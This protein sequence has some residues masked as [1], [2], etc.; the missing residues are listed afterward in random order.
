MKTRLHTALAAAALMS[1]SA[2]G[3]CDAPAPDARTQGVP[4][5]AALQPAVDASRRSLREGDRGDPMVQADL[6]RYNA[7]AAMFQDDARRA[8]AEDSLYALWSR[9]LD[10]ILWPELPAYYF[11]RISELG[12]LQALFDQ[13]G[14]PDSSTALGAYLREWR[15]DG[16]RTD[17][18]GYDTARERRG[19][20]G[21]FENVWFGLRLAR[22]AIIRGEA[23]QGL[24]LALD[25]L[26][27]AREI[28]G[29]RLELVAWQLIAAA[30]ETQGA[31]DDALH[32]CVLAEDFAA[33]LARKTRNRFP[34]LDT[35]ARRAQILGNRREMDAAIGLY[36]TCADEADREGMTLL[37]QRIL[38]RA[39][40]L[41]HAANRHEDGLRFFQGALRLSLAEGDSLNVPRH[42][43]NIARRHRILGN[44]DSCRVYLD[45]AERWVYG[46]S[47]PVNQARFPLMQAEYHAQIGDFA[48][49]DSL[50]ALALAR[51]PDFSP[52][53]EFSELHLELIRTGMERGRPAQAYRSIAL[54][55]SLRDRLQGTFTDRH[56]IAD[57]DLATAEFLGRQGL[58]ARAADALDR[59]DS[60]LAR[61]PDPVRGVELAGARGHLARR[62][63]DTASAEAAY[64]ECARL[65]D[66]AGDA[67]RGE[68]ARLWLASVLLDRGR[69]DAADSVLSSGK[70]SGGQRRFRTRV[71]AGIL[72]ARVAAQRGDLEAA[73]ARLDQARA[74]CRPESPPDL[75]VQLD[76]DSG[77]S[78]AALGRTRAAR[79]AY[80]RARDRLAAERR[81]AAMD[82]DVFPDRDLR[83]E[84][85]EAMV[86]TAVPATGTLEGRDAEA[87]LREVATVLPDWARD[88]EPGGV[89]AL[90]APQVVYL[91]GADATYRWTVDGR[92]ITLHRL[93][94]GAEILRAMGP[95][96]ADLREPSRLPSPDD[97]AALTEMLGGPAPSGAD[98]APLVIVPDGVLFAIPWATLTGTGGG[99]WVDSGPIVV[100]D[101]PL[102][103][104]AGAS[105]LPANLRLLAVGVD[106][107]A[108]ARR[109]GLHPLRHAEREARDVAASWPAANAVLEVGRESGRTANLLAEFEHYD[110]LHLSSHARAF[111]GLADQT[112]IYVAGTTGAP[113]TAAEIRRLDLHAELVFLSSCEAADGV[114]RGVGPAHAGLARSFLAAGAR[115]VIASGIR[116]DDEAARDLAVRF[117]AHWWTGAPLPAAL[118][119]AQLDLRDAGPRWAHPYYWAFHQVMA[120]YGSGSGQTSQSEK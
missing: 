47:N 52:I 115:H 116:V 28:G 48:T 106:S 43:A 104:S 64:R 82:D 101:A 37:E 53:G 65:A 93:P 31:L 4:L 120:A 12:R 90:A 111:Q 118:R 113:I 107:D 108:G 46:W 96:L 11:H 14:F 1:A 44:L 76:L 83:R 21:R 33:A 27:A 2:L 40:I 84:L 45:R 71:S 13:P 89:P 99:T 88:R 85:A 62:R 112:T 50:H 15:R 117:Y 39:G 61:R 35:R 109:A 32:A 77:R 29:W 20:L 80:I 119:M 36:R 6:D 63:D 8:V 49:V 78:L 94:A 102:L 60:A 72:R 91:T 67:D 59:A 73:R 25:E 75:L 38:N 110:V 114:R 92:R 42:L 24:R 97:L 66:D 3:G 103:G 69:P 5:A 87:I 79:D 70:D 34:L 18:S 23:D 19:E 105:R 54:L 74:L 16:P 26:P 57:L 98:G 86:N 10:N 68:L 22:F 9:D 7:L 81:S 100:A 41:T 17:G 51:T 30:L 55:D 58:F 56:E 95:V